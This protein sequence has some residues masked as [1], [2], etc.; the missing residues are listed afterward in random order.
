MK[1]ALLSA[2]ILACAVP[3]F[4][5]DGYYAGASIGQ[6]KQKVSG[7]IEFDDSTTAGKVFAGVKFNQSIALEAG[8]A[9]FGEAS[10]SADGARLAA[11]PQSFYAALVGSVPLGGQ[12]SGFGK[13]GVSRNS[14][15]LSASYG[16]DKESTTNR[17]TSALLGLGLR[18]TISPTV[19]VVAEYEDFGKVAK[20]EG[21]ALKISQFSVG[22]HVAF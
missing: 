12:L 21:D 5:A 3:A 11:K 17:T 22:V 8:Y 4:A 1:K 13:L 10:I 18:Y 6:A 19:S 7:T 2:L 15:D 16:L 20:D 9:N 14:T